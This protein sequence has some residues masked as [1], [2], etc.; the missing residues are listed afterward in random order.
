MNLSDYDFLDLG[1][2]KGGSLKF[3]AAMFG[4]RGVGVDIDPKK[5]ARAQANGVDCVEADATRLPLDPDSVSF[6]QMMHFLEHLPDQTIGEAVIDN[7]YRVA[8][9]FIYMTG[10]DFGGARYLAKHGL[11][12]CFHTW[13]GHPWKHTAEDLNTVLAK[14]D[15]PWVLVSLGRIMD[16]SSPVVAPLTTPANHL[17]YNPG[18]DGPK[19]QI[20]FEQKIYE[21]LAFVVLKSDRFSLGDI[22]ARASKPRVR[23][24]SLPTLYPPAETG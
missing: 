23:G 16:S 3:G 6:V 17:E 14:Y 20:K 21:S 9:D 24:G 2:S 11:K 19:P 15:R 10:P 1:A 7:A 5:V 8:T 4:G 12:K 22:L 13:H 18:T